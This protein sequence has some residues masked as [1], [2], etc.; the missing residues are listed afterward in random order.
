LFCY[1]DNA[2]GETVFVFQISGIGD[3]PFITT[4]GEAYITEVSE[5]SEGHQQIHFKVAVPE[6]C[7]RMD[8][9]FGEF[10]E[11]IPRPHPS[12]E[13][14]DFV[15]VIPSDLVLRPG[16]QLRVTFYELGDLPAS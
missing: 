4:Q 3:K 13:I 10:I 5:H 9:V 7:A 1:H 2:A 8:L 15:R 12:S 14:I 16:D 11:S 6:N